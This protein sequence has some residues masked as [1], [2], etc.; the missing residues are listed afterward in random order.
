MRSLLEWL[1]ALGVLAAAVWVAGPT[2]GRL[3]P[4]LP[5]TVTLVESELPA[6]PAGVPAGA[7]SAPLVILFDGSEVRLGM[8]ENDL[9]SGPISRFA[10]GSPVVER[11]VIGDR[12]ILSFQADRLLF[13]VVLDR[14]AKDRERQVTAI[15][16]R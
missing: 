3:I 1:L 12:A 13:W 14:I 5:A 16:L 8:T 11:G 7:T 15:Y 6:L 2:V 4:P 9:L 10:V